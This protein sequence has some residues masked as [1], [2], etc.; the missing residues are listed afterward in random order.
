MKGKIKILITNDDGV[1]AVGIVKLAEA[2][3][4]L[5]DVWVAAPSGQC[6][7][8]SQ[9]L[10]IFD[11]IT[12]EAVDFPVKVS[13]AY[14]IGGTPADCVKAAITYLMPEK[15]DV[16]FS[17]INSGYN[18]GYDICYSGTIGAAME[19]L[20]NG[21]PAIAFSTHHCG[22]FDIA[23]KYLEETARR[24]MQ[25]GLP[26]DAVV[27]VNFPDCSESELKGIL[28]NRKPAPTSMYKNYYIPVKDECGHPALLPQ[29]KE[30]TVDEVPQGSDVHALLS[31]YIS[32]GE[33]KCG[34]L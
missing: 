16:V 34:V 31:N 26:R 10:T 14:R 21:I 17:G 5:G 23:D 20:L 33:I 1:S 2:A 27:N 25:A 19:A 24:L 13:A 7:G 32:I 28:R 30:C 11:P 3:S 29:A 8:V 15:P 9:K 6:S 12:I 4:R 18:A 22:C